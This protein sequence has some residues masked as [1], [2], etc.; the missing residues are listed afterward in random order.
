MA[1]NIEDHLARMDRRV[2]SGTR[3]G[4]ETAIVQAGRTYP[5]DALDLWNALTT[6]ARLEKW[7][8]PISGDLRQGGKY[9]FTGNA[10]G[11]IQECV[12]PEHV[13]VTWEFGGGVSWLTVRL[14]PQTDGTR[15]ELEHEAHPMPGFSEVYGPGAV[16]VGWDGGFLGMAIHLAN[17]TAG[18]P[19][20]ADAAWPMS[21]EG[22]SFYGAAARAWGEADAASG[23][24]AA[25][26]LAR[27]ETTRRF[28]T[29]EGPGMGASEG[30]QAGEPA[31]E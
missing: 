7:F 29:G 6:P 13:K 17:P 23:T 1:F 12:E 25:D 30:E 9:Q 3:D 8:L 5:T 31:G 2:T 16:G 19:P 18:K 4:Q 28:Y 20:E 27:A 22:K 24:P 26:A 10:G 14:L 11:T 15:L 21:P